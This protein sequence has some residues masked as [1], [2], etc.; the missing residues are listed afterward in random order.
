[1][2]IEQFLAILATIEAVSK[3]TITG[4]RSAYESVTRE[5]EAWKKRADSAEA[6]VTRLNDLLGGEGKDAK[7]A[8]E[9][10]QTERDNLKTERDTFKAKAEGLEADIKRSQ[11]LDQLG[12]VAAKMGIDRE[13]LATAIK[14]GML[15]E[16]KTVVVGEGD[17]AKI[18]VDGKDI[19][20]YIKAQ[21]FLERALIVPPA[22]GSDQGNPDTNTSNGSLQ[23]QNSG[24][25]Q[26]PT[27]GQQQQTP[28]AGASGGNAGK[29]PILGA[30]AE[31]GFKV[32]GAS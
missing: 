3:D 23:P 13:G 8:L 27:G 20:E 15:P 24:N 17:A 30:I 32:P 5:S 7:A 21:P 12:A 18:Q 2:N 6:S 14:A 29:N 1:M 25:Q 26:T 28:T 16:D 31:L 9:A 4:I 11:K 22:N 19:K 10:L